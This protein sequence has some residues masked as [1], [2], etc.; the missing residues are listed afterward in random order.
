MAKFNKGHNLSP[1]RR[2]GSINKR[3]QSFIAA[4]EAR[5]YSVPDALLDIHEMALKEFNQ[6]RDEDRIAALRIAADMA[7][8]LASYSMPKLKAIEIV[9]NNSL[10]SMTVQEKIDAMKEAVKL[11]E[12]EVKKEVIQ[13]ETKKDD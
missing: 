6:G 13:I 3:S 4:L 2:K 9:K 12:Q 10:E 7:K 5:N 11:M 1:G 8:E